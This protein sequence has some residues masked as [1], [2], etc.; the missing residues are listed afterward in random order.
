MSVAVRD[1]GERRPPG[2]DRDG[3]IGLRLLDG[4]ELRSAGA[5]AQI[6]MTARRVLVFL[7]LQEGPVRRDHLSGMIWP[8]VSDASASA[9]LRSA[10]WR[11]RAPGLPLIR[12][13]TDQIALARGI[14][15][16]LHRAS[17][18]ALDLI[19]GRGDL[20]EGMRWLITRGTL[21]P[22][23][24][25]DWLLMERERFRQLRLHALECLCDRLSDAGR[26]GEAV[27]A[28]LAA[29]ATEP[30]RESA[31]RVLVRTYLLEGNRVEAERQYERCRSMLDE[32]LGVPPSPQMRR[33]LDHA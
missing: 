17:A 11:L 27:Q 26:F 28:G 15:V 33:L 5:V 25:D 20:D 16:D 22:G 12:S 10:L 8:D 13:N 1:R 23:W 6:P 2:E 30:L 7:A 31:H 19:R 3:P 9:S 4:F 14:H 32:E 18:V 21:L 29:V 24:Y